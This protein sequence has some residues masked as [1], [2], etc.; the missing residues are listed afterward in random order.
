[1]PNVSFPYID[2]PLPANEAYPQGMLARRPL[3]LATITASNGNSMRWVVLPDTG[4]DSCLFPMALA[5]LLK[6]DVL[7]L[8]KAMT[9]GVGNGSNLTYYDTLRIDLGS[10]IAF[11]SFVGF[12]QGLDGAGLGL[13][14]QLGFFEYYNVD[15]LHSQ[16]QYVVRTL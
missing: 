14:G 7:H 6:I 12:T 1:M 2:F 3:A 15:F 10:G 8:P 16:G 4:A 13:L 5:I 9:G 11:T